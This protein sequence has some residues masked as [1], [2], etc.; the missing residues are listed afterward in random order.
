MNGLPAYFT[1]VGCNATAADMVCVS[2][3]RD[4]IVIRAAGD[5]L[6]CYVCGSSL[7]HV[8]VVIRDCVTS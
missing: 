4:I 5:E 6:L 8:N 7:G 1:Q 3:V 2:I